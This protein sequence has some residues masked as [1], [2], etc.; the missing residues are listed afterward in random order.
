M[1]E[2]SEEKLR[3]EFLNIVRALHDRFKRSFTLASLD[4]Q[5]FF[6]TPVPA[7]DKPL[8]FRRSRGDDYYASYIRRHVFQNLHQRELK[9]EVILGQASEDQNA[10]GKALLTDDNNP[11]SGWQDEEAPHHW[12]RE[13]IDS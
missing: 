5:V 12:K 10:E 9:F 1:G 8:T 6:C 11:L 2:L 4:H 13:F 7:T 3:E